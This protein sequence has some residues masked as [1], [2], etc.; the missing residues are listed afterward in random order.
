MDVLRCLSV[1]S[2]MLCVDDTTERIAVEQL[3][4]VA[5]A[6]YIEERFVS[7]VTHE[8]SGLA[9]QALSAPSARG[10]AHPES[11]LTSSATSRWRIQGKEIRDCCGR[12]GCEWA[13]HSSRAAG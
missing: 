11:A 6:A 2:V 13:L 12:W 3:V 1:M 8:S 4:L 7:S 5:V 10:S 9:K